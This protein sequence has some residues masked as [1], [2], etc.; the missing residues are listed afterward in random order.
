MNA[1]FA[2][3]KWLPLLIVALLLLAGCG[4][5]RSGPPTSAAAT[6]GCPDASGPIVEPIVVAAANNLI[7]LNEDGSGQH[8]LLSL[9]EEASAAFPAW[10]PDGRT[11]AYALRR[12]APSPKLR[13]ILSVICGI[14]RATGKGRLLATGSEDDW[15]DEPGW[16]ADSQSLVLTLNRFQV[17]AN[18]QMVDKRHVARYDLATKT[19]QILVADAHSP[20][21]SS[22]GDRLAYIAVDPQS[23]TEALFVAR[24]DGQEA[25]PLIALQRPY[26]SAMWPRWSPDD[27]QIVFGA[28]MVGGED[29]ERYAVCVISV[30]GQGFQ[31]LS[32]D[33]NN[34]VSVD[35]GSDSSK[36][37]YA[38]S[39]RGL[40][41]RDLGQDQ[42]QNVV[43]LGDG[44]GVSWARR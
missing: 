20:A 37:A 22:A 30:D 28:G 42:A 35:W 44:M 14:E 18:Q 11:L 24:H 39:G 29:D 7:A 36:I 34:V 2:R 33:V 8:W 21:I 23:Q 17:G 25:Q 41:I 26:V 32:K 31:Q 13:G 43:A 19:L 10:S 12:P 5:A 6:T 15:L 16:S 38:S 1:R 4:A 9:S 40:S 27:T 3:L